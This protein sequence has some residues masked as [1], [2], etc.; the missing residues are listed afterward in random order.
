M[1]TETTTLVKETKA[2]RAERLKLAKNP[3]ECFEEIRQFARQGLTAVPD[4]WIKT[5]FRWWGV[6]TQGDGGG[7]IGGFCREERPDP[8]FM[9]P[10]HLFD[11]V[12]HSS[13]FH[14]FSGVTVTCADGCA[15]FTLSMNHQSRY[16]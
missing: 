8:Y 10:L 16:V 4:A 5:Y 12:V 11:G 6:Y 9:L 1:S 2:K 14:D 3:W 7:A 15:D 13:P